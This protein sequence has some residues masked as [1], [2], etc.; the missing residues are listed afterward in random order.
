MI[1]FDFI[2]S[3]MSH[4]INEQVYDAKLEND[5]KTLRFGRF[6]TVDVL[7]LSLLLKQNNTLRRLSL[8]EVIIEPNN[9]TPLIDSIADKPLIE[10]LDLHNVQLSTEQLGYVLNRLKHNRTLQ[11]L[12]LGE[13]SAINPDNLADFI[14][15]HND[16]Y[17]II[18]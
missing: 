6:M 5:G 7:S 16:I 8:Y 11:I 10:S 1:K 15:Y 18:S 12:D 3:Y 13:N 2:A 9:I 14:R 4:Q 17:S